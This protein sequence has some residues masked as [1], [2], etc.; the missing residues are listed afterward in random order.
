MPE[1]NLLEAISLVCA[2]YT[3]NKLDINNKK[4]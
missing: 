2:T 3:K 1:T 4:P